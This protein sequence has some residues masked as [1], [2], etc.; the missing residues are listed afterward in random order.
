MP[1]QISELN[2]PLRVTECPKTAV[3]SAGCLNFPLD[4]GKLELSQVG[5]KAP[6]LSSGHGGNLELCHQDTSFATRTASFV[7][8][9]NC[10]QLRYVWLDRDLLRSHGFDRAFDRGS[11]G[12]GQNNANEASDAAA[13]Q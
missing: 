11:D 7:T 12:H 10:G 2:Q 5:D 3:K 4:G 9:T 13:N 1:E 6:A 8:R